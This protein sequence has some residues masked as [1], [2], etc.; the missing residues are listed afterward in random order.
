MSAEPT[1]LGLRGKP[2]GFAITAILTF[3]FVLVGYDQGKYNLLKT[4]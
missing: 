4:G 3:G 2:L 1:Y